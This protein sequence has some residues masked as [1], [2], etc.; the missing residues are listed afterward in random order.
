MAGGRNNKRGGNPAR[1]K[2]EPAVK[3]RTTLVNEQESTPLEKRTI[4]QDEARSTPMLTTAEVLINMGNRQPVVVPQKVVSGGGGARSRKSSA[5][6][7]RTKDWFEAC[8]NSGRLDHAG[9]LAAD[10]NG[11]VRKTLFPKL[12]FIMSERQMNFSK[13]KG[14]FCMLICTGMGL[15]VEDEDVMV[16]WWEAHKMTVGY[17][18]NQ[19]RADV[20][21]AVKL[22][23]QRK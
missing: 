16:S 5:Q 8:Q 20:S 14:S 12:K 3:R 4:E 23:F 18:L 2:D 7:M 6:G 10:V 13:E 9:I 15:C 22:C 21:S 1:G 19:K 17:I 11:Y